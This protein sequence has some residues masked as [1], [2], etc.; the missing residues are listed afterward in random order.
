MWEVFLFG[1]DKIGGIVF[2][3]VGVCVGEVVGLFVYVDVYCDGIGG[4]YCWVIRGG[5]GVV[6]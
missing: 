3:G 5:W 4:W 1:F 6:G 2:V